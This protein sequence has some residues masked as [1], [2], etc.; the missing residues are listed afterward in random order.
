[1]V[2]PK[3]IISTFV[4]KQE[5]PYE[6]RLSRTVPWEA[7]GEIPLAHPTLKK[8][9]WNLEKYEAIIFDLGKVIFDL[10][11]DLIFENWAEMS[12]AKLDHKKFN[13]HIE[14][15]NRKF[16]CDQITVELFR[17][18]FLRTLGFDLTDEEFDNG[19]CSLYLDTYPGVEKLIENLKSR[20]RIVALTNTNVIHSNVWKTK[21]EKTLKH[22]EKVFSSHEI[23][24][25]KPEKGAY[26]MVLDY[27]GL[28][29]DKVIFID[30][31]LENVHSAGEMGMRTILVKSSG[32]MIL[33][34]KDICQLNSN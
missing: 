31:N 9:I 11:T 28:D 24:I 8:S 21:Y 25:R 4:T 29:S 18:N 5:E 26:K 13:P 12:G 33:D 6:G 32:Q 14:E 19:W 23:R 17:E 15:L 27:L 30:H 22:F 34:L 16:E 2:Y 20:Y 3:C 1:M 10:S 7:W